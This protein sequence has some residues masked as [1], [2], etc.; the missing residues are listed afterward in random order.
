MRILLNGEAVEVSKSDLDE[1][2][3]ELGYNSA[4]VATALNGE[5]VPVTLRGG[6]NLEPGDSIEVL[7]PMQGG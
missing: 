7:A 5:F 6:T 2:L 1:A 4:I 3:L